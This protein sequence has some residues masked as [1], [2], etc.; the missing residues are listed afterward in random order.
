MLAHRIKTNLWAMT[1]LCGGV[2]SLMSPAH[3]DTQQSLYFRSAQIPFAFRVGDHAL[4]AGTYRLEPFTTGSPSYY[5]K[6]VKT[7]QSLMVTCLGGQE[8]R[9]T[10]L[11]F[12][13]DETG[14]V[15]KKVQ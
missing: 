2:F 4:P 11:T 6:N 14:Y 5:L 9:P 1:V 3:A 8:Q 12:D 10:Q 13:K 15:L 7:G